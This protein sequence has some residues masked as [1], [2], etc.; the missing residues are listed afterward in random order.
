MS[1][2]GCWNRTD[3]IAAR[4][5]S[6]RD[7]IANHRR[8]LAWLFR[9]AVLLSDEREVLLIVKV[10]RLDQQALGRRLARRVCASL[11]GFGT[12]Q[13][14]TSNQNRLARRLALCRVAFLPHPVSIIAAHRQ[15]QTIFVKV[16][17]F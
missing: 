12:R 11:A 14:E 13:C 2:E 17:L 5:A 1:D 16:R 10:G 6:L 9:I 3:L 8:P 7:R 15:S 4:Q